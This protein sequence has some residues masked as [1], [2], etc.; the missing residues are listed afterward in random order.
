MKDPDTGIEE[1]IPVQP[2]DR[3]TMLRTSDGIEVT[4]LSDGEVRVL[5]EESAVNYITESC[6]SPYQ[7]KDISTDEPIW[8][9][10]GYGDIVEA[11]D[12]VWVAGWEPVPA[13]LIGHRHCHAALFRRRLG[14]PECDH[15]VGVDDSDR[16]ES[17]VSKSDTPK[18]R[19]LSHSFNFCPK[20]GKPLTKENLK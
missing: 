18:Q 17:L 5:D 10:L 9:L 11:K 7:S 1:E 4:R 3:F 20:C 19:P 6:I 2:Q 13:H 12:E 16:Q 14:D 15:I 8:R